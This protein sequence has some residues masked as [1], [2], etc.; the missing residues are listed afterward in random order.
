MAAH[1]TVSYVNVG[2]SV[3]GTLIFLALSLTVGRG[4][5]ARLIRWSN[6]T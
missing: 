3:A 2:A 1:G 4:L 6:A 5:I